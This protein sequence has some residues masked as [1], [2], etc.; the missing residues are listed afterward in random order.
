MDTGIQV[1]S[2]KVA[3]LGDSERRL[4]SAF[5]AADPRLRSPYFDLRYVEAA[6]DVAPGG[7][8]AVIHRAGTVVGFLPYQRR[9]ATLQPL[10][11]PLS[12]FHGVVAAP[13]ADIDLV[14]V[15]RA[16]GVD[17]ARFTGLITDL[18]G[19]GGRARHAMAADLSGGFEAYEA[20]RSAAFLK[21]KRRRARALARD[22]G[23]VV[24]T[25]DHPT[26]EL[27]D[28]VIARKRAQIQRTH[29]HDIFAC[30]W[31]E[32]LLRR[33]DAID[34]P[35]FGLKLAVLRAGDRVIAAELG[36]T[37]GARHHLWFP[38]YDPA[39]AKYSP[40]ALMTLETLRAATGQGISRVD[41]GPSEELYKED[42]A[43]RME[44]VFE[45]VVHGRPSLAARLGPLP[46]GAA[47]FSAAGER[48]GRR[49]DRIS[50]CEPHLIGQ[51]RGAS[52]LV[53]GL[54]IRHPRLG[55]G[56]GAGLGLGLSL[57]LLAD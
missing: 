16:L 34:E 19:S 52:S 54:A 3:E 18:A 28:L 25:L 49:L 57:G 32:T 35:D 29:Q 48:L 47:R 42:F 40:G 36:L 5:R 26:P 11:A 39:F 1:E 44:P 43:D 56:L 55:A 7:R 24:F 27:L 10:A 23:S 12:D 41:F 8:L 50:A 38:I 2:L 46:S 13:A 30:G 37:S 31:T 53:T 33:L 6:G 14:E 4:W 45:G 20:G 21:D 51:M 22:H 9:G 17:R 15:V